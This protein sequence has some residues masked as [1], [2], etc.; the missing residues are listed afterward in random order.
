M[1]RRNLKGRVTALEQATD[2]VREHIVVLDLGETMEG[3][4]R[5]AAETY[6]TGRVVFVYTGV[7]RR[8][9]LGCMKE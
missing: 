6:G 7:P 4:E 8:H 3:A 5:R 1:T 2:D 9:S